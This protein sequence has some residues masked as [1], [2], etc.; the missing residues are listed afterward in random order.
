M[1]RGAD[2]DQGTWRGNAQPGI[3]TDLSSRRWPLLHFP[4]VNPGQSLCDG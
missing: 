4:R 2:P 3:E 1:N